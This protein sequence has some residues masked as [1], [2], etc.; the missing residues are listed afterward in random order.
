LR[1]EL[2]PGLVIHLQEQQVVIDD[3]DV[4]AV[5]GD[6]EAA[7]HPSRLDGTHAGQKLQGVFHEG[8]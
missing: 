6:P 5:E 3:A 1:L 8:G 7:E 4:V 2:R